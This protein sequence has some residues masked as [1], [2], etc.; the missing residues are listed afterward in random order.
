MESPSRLDDDEDDEQTEP[1]TKKRKEGVISRLLGDVIT[2][3]TNK[4]PTN[5]EMIRSEIQCYR[6]DVIA[7]LN[8]EPLKW[9]STREVQYKHLKKIVKKY[10]C[11]LVTSVRSEV[12]GAVCTKIVQKCLIYKL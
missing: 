11:M 1:A 10:L 5:L 6:H 3:E 12:W 9:W 2:T 8:D 4:K 7:G